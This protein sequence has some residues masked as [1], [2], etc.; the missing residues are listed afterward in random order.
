[1]LTACTFRKGLLGISLL[2]CGLTLAVATPPSQAEDWPPAEPIAVPSAA[3]Q[4]T[5]LPKSIQATSASGG[6]WTCTFTF[7]PASEPRSVALVGSFNHWEPDATPMTRS[8]SGAWTVEQELTPGVHEYKF[9]I[10]GDRWVHDPRNP[11]R[12]PDGHGGQN[13]VLRLGRL[14]TLTQSDAQLGDGR[15]DVVGLAH[16]P[17]LPLYIQAL[18]FGEV[19]VRYRTL[20]H[21]VQ[22]VR[23]A[24]LGREP[25]EMPIVAAGPLFAYREARIQVPPQDNPRSPN[26]RFVEYTFVLDDG[27]GP[28]CDPHTYRFSF[29][30]YTVFDTPAWA[31][32]AAWYQIMPD[33]FRNGDPSNDHEPL[34]VWTSAW[35]EPSPWEAATDG[36]FYTDA[37][38]NRRYGGD[39]QGIE[40]SLPYLRELGVNVLLLTPIFQAPSYHKYDVQNFLHID[41]ELS[42]KGDYAE[43]AARENLLDPSTWEWTAGDKRFLQFLEHA[44]AQGFKVVI[45]AVFNHVGDQHPAFVDVRTNGAT[46]R[47][48]DWFE[49][50]SWQPF[51]YGMWQGFEH[52]PVF[53]KDRYGFA[54]TGVEQHLFAVTRRWMDPNGD[55]DPS[56][57]VDGWR[58]DVPEDVPLPFWAAWRH[59]VKAI[60]PNALIIGE[61]WNRADHWLDGRH[62]DGVMNY[63]FARVATHFIFDVQTQASASECAS[64]LAELSLLYP[65]AATLVSQNVIDTHDTDR[66]ASMAQ[67]PDRLYDRQNRVQDNYPNYDNAKPSETS[68]RKARLALFLQATFV[69]APLIYYGDEV[70]M[71]GADD[72]TNRKPMLWKDL[73]PYAEPTENHVM[74]DQLAWYRQILELRQ[75][76]SALRT[77]DFETLLADDGAHVIAFQRRNADQRLVVLLNASATDATVAVPMSADAPT[78]WKAIFG[79]EQAPAVSDGALQVAVPSFGGVVLEAAAAE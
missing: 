14:A 19:T 32:D 7:Q 73:E 64:R 6:I 52:M 77:G 57:G 50:K 70:G 43:V 24:V 68:Y 63:E 79:A 37:V 67:N 29:T 34:R 71:W 30:Q 3:D 4:I 42:V 26:V 78:Q 28:V 36:N 39:I 5:P 59:Q 55:G 18:S 25:V 12:V 51:V 74:D 35:F 44:H 13:S 46:S 75:K 20:A 66:I 11:E 2:I 27:A 69:G 48:A 16:H 1:M 76:N 58:M 31:H 61:A 21:D 60:N 45:D 53:R 49:V 23:L 72:P 8:D 41:E 54:G 65:R 38:F 40:A 56:D 22:H 33:R 10:N 17:P 15:I 62:F 9:V 47:Y